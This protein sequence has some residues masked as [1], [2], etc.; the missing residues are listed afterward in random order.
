MKNPPTKLGVEKRTDKFSWVKANEG[1]QLLDLV[2]GVLLGHIFPSKDEW[3]MIF[4]YDGKRYSGSRSSLEQA[5]K[6]LD[7]LIHKI[8]PDM[9]LEIDCSAIIEPWKGNL[10]ME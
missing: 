7:H 6:A 9:W 1:Y 8:N 3:V 10:P 4:Q 5:F 2:S